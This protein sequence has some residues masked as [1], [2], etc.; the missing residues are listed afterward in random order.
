MHCAPSPRCP[1]RKQKLTIVP[2]C[3]RRQPRNDA[4]SPRPLWP[5][6]V[7]CAC[8]LLSRI[9]CSVLC[10]MPPHDRGG[11][12]PRSH[13]SSRSYSGQSHTRL[14]QPH[15]CCTRAT[16]A[17]HPPLNPKCPWAAGRIAYVCIHMRGKFQT[18]Q[19][20]TAARHHH[21]QLLPV[22]YR[23]SLMQ[24]QTTA[25]ALSHLF[26]AVC[27]LHLSFICLL[28]TCHEGLHT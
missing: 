9:H 20:N 27:H 10:V 16:A 23:Y 12:N 2:C 11:N 15:Q 26:E 7:S 4:S 8:P 22:G 5:H 14:S 28:P 21:T 13:H 24:L 1:E 17:L 18:L 25:L 3:L 19:H 6:H